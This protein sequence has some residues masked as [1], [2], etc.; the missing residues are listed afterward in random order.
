MV[1][2][3]SWVEDEINAEEE[4]KNR[5]RVQNFGRIIYRNSEITNSTTGTMMERVT[6]SQELTS[7]T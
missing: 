7:L 6:E 1:M 3:W 4:V 5:D 2:R